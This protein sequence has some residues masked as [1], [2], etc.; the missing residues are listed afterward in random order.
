MAT[1][2]GNNGAISINGIAVL[3]VR[4]FAID[5]TADTIE[6]TV[7]GTD[8]RTYVSGMSSFSGSADVYFDS[9]DYDT[10]ETT[11]NPTSGLVGASGVAGKFYINYAAAGN[12]DVFQGTIIVTGYSVNSSMDG[13]VEGSISFQGTGALTYSTGSSV[14]YP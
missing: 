2:T 6:T 10:N 3:A 11:F 8:V 7:M 5:M 1:L 4:N 12:D 9:T 14:S 13:M